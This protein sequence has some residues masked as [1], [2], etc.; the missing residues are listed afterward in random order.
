MPSN[1]MDDVLEA[2]HEVM[3]QPWGEGLVGKKFPWN[4]YASCRTH[5]GEAWYAVVPCAFSASI[6]HTIRTLR[7]Q[8]CSLPKRLYYTAVPCARAGAQ[9][10]A[11]Q[12]DDT[13]ALGHWY[14]ASRRIVAWPT[15]LVAARMVWCQRTAPVCCS[16]DRVQF[17]CLIP[18]VR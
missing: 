13:A 15:W 1:F 5:G 9:V 16:H 12:E 10:Q 11:K 3:A 18:N 8:S 4:W 17:S 14:A 2:Y 7:R 6:V